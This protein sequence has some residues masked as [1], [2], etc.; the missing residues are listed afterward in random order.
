MLPRNRGRSWQDDP[1]GRLGG[2]M[3]NCLRLV[4]TDRTSEYFAIPTPNCTY[5][6]NS[7]KSAASRSSSSPVVFVYQTPGS[8][9][10]AHMGGVFGI[11]R[12]FP[13]ERPVFE[14]V[15]KTMMPPPRARDERPGRAEASPHR[16]TIDNRSHVA[17]V[18]HETGTA[19][20]LRPCVRGL[21]GCG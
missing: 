12:E 20:P 14:C 15:R 3:K 5:D 4:G 10:I 16:Q 21:S 18:S 17:R 1:G 13:P 2:A 9:R 11:P 8:R 19:R 6:A 7:P